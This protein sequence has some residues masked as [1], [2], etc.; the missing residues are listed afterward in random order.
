MIPLF[1]LLAS[2]NPRV[3]CFLFEKID[4]IGLVLEIKKENDTEKF[5]L[6]LQTTDMSAIQIYSQLG[7]VHI[8]KARLYHL[9]SLSIQ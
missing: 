8:S 3:I 1:S 4:L 2:W 5:H 6:T 7:S 9:E